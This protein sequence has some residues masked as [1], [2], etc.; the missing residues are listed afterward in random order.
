MLILPN[1][2][3]SDNHIENLEL[4]ASKHGPGQRIT[5]LIPY[6]IEM[7]ARYNPDSLKTL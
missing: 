6:W 3:R 1:G 7:L 4:W 5:D 2:I